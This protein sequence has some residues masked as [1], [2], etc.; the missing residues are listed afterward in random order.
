MIT[1]HHVCMTDKQRATLID[2]YD[3]LMRLAGSVGERKRMVDA[4]DRIQ[5]LERSRS[6]FLTREECVVIGLDVD[7][8]MYA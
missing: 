4:A 5:E 3:C 1:N 2:H 7:A 6:R 8:E